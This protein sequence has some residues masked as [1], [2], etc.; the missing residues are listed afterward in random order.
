MVYWYCMTL[1][2]KLLYYWKNLGPG[3]VT[4]AADNDPSAIATYATAGA[5]FGFALSWMLLWI[6]PFMIAIQN[7]CARIGA[8]SGCGL[9]G[10]IRKHYPAWLLFLAVGSILI[11]NTLNIGADMYGMS[12]AV[13]LMV[14]F[15]P[16]QVA[17]VVMSV[18]IMAMVIFLRYRQ[19][20]MFFKWF[21]LSLFVYGV[22]LVLVRP[23][24]LTIAWHMLIPTIIPSRA[25]LLTAFAVLGTTL[26]PYLYFWQAS[27]E[28]EELK[29]DRPGIRVCKFR[30]VHKGMLGTIGM[31]TKVGM[32]ASN[33]ISFFILSLLASVIWNTGHATQLTTLREAAIALEP[34]AGQYAFHLFTLGIISSGLLAIPVLAGS[35]AYALSEMMGWPA[36]I[37]K[38]FNRA[39]PFY[40]VMVG[41][42]IV[43]MIV[44]FVGITPVQALLWSAIIMGITAPLLIG[45][46]VHMAKNPA[47]VGPHRSS[48]PV[49][50]LGLGA[51]FFL[52]TGTLFVLFS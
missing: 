5:Q 28:A 9:A 1:K 3:L 4:G 35:A 13:N 34:F 16:V 45:L 29:Q 12:A 27:Q 7:M 33:F 21:A 49:H 15:V 41:S 22:A 40:L 10:N 52:L 47:I 11:A 19:I 48:I 8:L 39:R 17:A 23:D 50:T 25:F 24:W 18:L 46:V 42:V 36:S 2:T 14:P 44:P 30:P 37:D 20:E 6:L 26:S 51:M 43:S 38:P 32:I 31:D